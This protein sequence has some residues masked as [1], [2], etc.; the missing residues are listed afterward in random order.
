MV[1]LITVAM[2]SAIVVGYVAYVVLSGRRS[3]TMQLSGLRASLPFV[4]IQI[5]CGDCSGD[6]ERPTKTFVDRFGRCA[7]CGGGSYTLASKQG[8]YLQAVG[9]A[10]GHGEASKDSLSADDRNEAS[11]FVQCLRSAA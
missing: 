1:M 7:Q 3:D 10:R 2:T 5:I 6:S 8:V 11:L 4:G 9:A